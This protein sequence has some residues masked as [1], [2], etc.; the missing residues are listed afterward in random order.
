M[1]DAPADTTISDMLDRGEIE[2]SMAPWAPF[3]AA[4]HNPDIGWLFDDPTSA[5]KDYYQRTGIFPIC[6]RV[7]L[8]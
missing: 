5:A 8:R 1:V 2:S 4:R 7:G 3:G 6:T